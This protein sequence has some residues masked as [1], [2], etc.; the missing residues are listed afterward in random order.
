MKVIIQQDFK[1]LGKRGDVVSVND[2]Y[3]RNYLIPRG[4]VIE[5]TESNMKQLKEQKSAQ[6]HR[7]ER[8]TAEAQ[9]LAEKLTGAAVVIKAKA[10]EAGKLFGSVTA[11]E[12]GAKLSE[13]LGITIDKR[14]IELPE[15]I[16]S[17]GTHPV[18]VKL[19]PGVVSNCKVHVTAEEEE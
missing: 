15:P 5:A 9:K 14:Q 17:V 19:H 18:T 3:A 1:K 4:I 16:K 13:K 7:L 2:G 10:G 11:A 6:D 12:I 8:E